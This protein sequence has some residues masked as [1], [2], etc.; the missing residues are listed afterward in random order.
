MAVC[1]AGATAVTLMAPQTLAQLLEVAVNHH[2]AG[3]LKKAEQLYLKALKHDP[4]QPDALNLLGVLTQQLGNTQK[5]LSLFEQA[6]EAAPHL[7]SIHFNK[8]KSL[9]D[10]GRI[11]GAKAAYETAL[12]CDPM[13]LDAILNLSVLL[14][15]KNQT[16]EALKYLNTLIKLSPDHQKAHYNIGKCYQAQ[17]RFDDALIA[18]NKALGFNPNDHDAH[19]AIANTFSDIANYDDAIKHIKIA[20]TIKPGW[21]QA[22]NN[23]ANYLAG[24]DKHEEAVSVFDQ[25]ISCEPNNINARVNRSLSLLTLGK[26]EAGWQDYKYRAESDAPYYRTV[27]SELPRWDG[28]DPRDKS[29]LVWNEQGLGEEI[30]FASLLADLA[31]IAGSCT[32][33]C[34]PKLYLVFKR[35]FSHFPGLEITNSEHTQFTDSDFDFQTSLADLG[36]FFRSSLSK[37]PKPTPYLAWNSELRNSFRADLEERFGKNRKFVGISWASDNPIIGKE[38]TVPL[39]QWQTLL[40]SPGVTFINV[41]YGSAAMDTAVL[42]PE[43][44]RN[45]VTVNTV[46]LD[47]DLEDTLALLGALDE[48]VTSSNTTAHLAGAAGVQTHVMVP[49][50]RARI[51]YWFLEGSSGPWYAAVHLHRPNRAGTFEDAMG[52]IAKGLL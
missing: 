49:R 11:E 5:A 22:Y 21:A 31:K 18:F 35:S 7:A 44:R 46:N 23:W 17:C 26:L 36:R 16:E 13:F 3:N 37:F 32:L 24:Q 20:I 9:H 52:N 42:P 38:K 14:Q 48:F 28:S 34:S 25:A 8:G 4:N 47:G 10:D 45:I 12:S 30:L 33:L 39:G 51:W 50:A 29:I 2:Q 15:E 40:S 27:A 43:L 1:A 19:F 41:Q 6:I